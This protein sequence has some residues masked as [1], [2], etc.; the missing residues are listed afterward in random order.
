MYVNII[1]YIACYNN[2][3]ST[4]VWLHLKFKFKAFSITQPKTLNLNIEDLFYICD[5][6]LCQNWRF[7]FNDRLDRHPT[8]AVS[9]IKS[10]K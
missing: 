7:G 10:A 4:S 1:A 2:I 9:R 3:I 6:S 8:L 5:T